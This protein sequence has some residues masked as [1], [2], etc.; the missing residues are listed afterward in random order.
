MNSLV[1]Y[2]KKNCQKK[3]KSDFSK[4]MKKKAKQPTNRG[5][6]GG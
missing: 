6:T 4:T 1:A 2:K 3:I 5:S